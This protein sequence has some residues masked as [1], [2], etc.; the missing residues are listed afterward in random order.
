LIHLAHVPSQEIQ[1][2]YIYYGYW[3]F[4]CFHGLS[5]RCYNYSDIGSTCGRVCSS[6]STKDT[7]RVAPVANKMISHIWGKNREVL[8]T[9]GMYPWSFVTQILCNGWKSH[10]GDDFNLTTRNPC[11]VASL[12]AAIWNPDRIHN[13]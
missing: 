3:F 11:L 1:R 10:G 13:L 12:L 4:P 8:T 6:Q 5:I 7:R 9:S 2:S